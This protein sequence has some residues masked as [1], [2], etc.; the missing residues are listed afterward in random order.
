MVDDH[1]KENQYSPSSET[2]V[3]ATKGRTGTKG[4]LQKNEKK[5]KSD[6]RKAN[7]PAPKQVPDAVISSQ[8]FDKLLVSCQHLSF[9]SGSNLV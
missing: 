5:K 7:D 9:N 4:F 1:A 3:T 6:S 2:L 8:E